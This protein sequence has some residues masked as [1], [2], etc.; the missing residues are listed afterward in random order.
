MPYLFLILFIVVIAVVFANI[1]IYKENAYNNL[2][3]KRFI[4][5]LKDKRENLF[6]SNANNEM[7]E[8][9]LRVKL[10][11]IYKTNVYSQ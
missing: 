5:I 2:L 4:I 11:V 8:L 1:M 3:F 10:V 7:I 9:K 6:F